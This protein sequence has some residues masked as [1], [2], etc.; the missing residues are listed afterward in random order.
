MAR[1]VL[2]RLVCPHVPTVGVL[3]PR[4]PSSVVTQGW[5]RRRRGPGAGQ[6]LYP[7][8]STATRGGVEPSRVR[9]S[10]DGRRQLALRL[11]TVLAMILSLVGPATAVFTTPVVAAVTPAP[12]PAPPAA[13]EAAGPWVM[14]ITD[15]AMRRAA[16]RTRQVIRRTTTV[17]RTATGTRVLTTSPAPTRVLVPGTPTFV[18]AGSADGALVGPTDEEL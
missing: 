18:P 1:G 7:D 9:V 17:T 14:S 2:L 15:V 8:S 11:L 5:D 16:L 3:L 6:G 12:R 4:R 10:P 13:V